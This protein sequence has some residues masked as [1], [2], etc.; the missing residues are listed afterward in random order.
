MGDRVLVGGPRG[1]FVVPADYDWHLLVGDP[2]ALPAIRRRLEELPAGTRVT[3][4]AQADPADRL[5]FVTQ[6]QLDSFRNDTRHTAIIVGGATGLRGYVV[7]E[8]RGNTAFLGHVEV[9][10]VAVPIWSQRFG[11]LLFYDVGDAAPSLD[12]LYL[13]NDVGLG[14]RWLLVQ[15]NSAVIRFDWAVP[16]QDGTVTRAGLPGR[17]SA[18]FEQVF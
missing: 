8:F 5:P 16:L 4:I 17:V 2:T 12:Q 10:T 13:R 7:G 18:G 15:A 6:A 9:R 11:T 3:V 1:S 14:L